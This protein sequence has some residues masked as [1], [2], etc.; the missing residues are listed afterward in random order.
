MNRNQ[1]TFSA[2]NNSLTFVPKMFFL[3]SHSHSLDRNTIHLIV[4]CF[5][6]VI[7]D[8]CFCRRYSIIMQDPFLVFTFC[9]LRVH[10]HSHCRCVFKSKNGW[11][12]VR[13]FRQCRLAYTVHS[14]F[15]H[16]I[17]SDRIQSKCVLDLLSIAKESK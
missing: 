16:F 13:G 14:I 15:K 2:T 3:C 17:I 8:F 12:I 11:L 5:Q 9:L 6:F 10:S 4:D 1:L 7:Y